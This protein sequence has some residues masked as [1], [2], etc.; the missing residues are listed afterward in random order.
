MGRWRLTGAR[1][2]LLLAGALTVWGQVE[3]WSGLSS[4]V[5]RLVVALA[6]LPAPLSLLFR[7]RW[8]IAVVVVAFGSIPLLEIL[9]IDSDGPF[10]PVLAGLIA[11]GS[12]A[13]YS[14]HPVIAYVVAVLLVWI[15]FVG[16]AGSD[17]TRA[18]SPA[19]LL[20][21]AMLVAMGWAVGRGIA[22]GSL[23]ARLARQ[24]A[25]IAVAEQRLEI[26]RELHDIVA[27]SV[28]VMTMHA[29]GVRRML[30]PG[31]EREALLVV[32][33]TGRET[34]TELQRLLG[35]LRSDDQALEARPRLVDADELLEPARAAGLVAALRIEGDPRPLPEGVDLSAYRILQEAVTN[36]LR[37][38]HATRLD[39]VI[40]YADDAV[41]L[42]ITDDGPGRSTPVAGNGIVGM[43]ERTALWGGSFEAGPV[44]GRGFRVLA[45]VPLP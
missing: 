15:A 6:M 22:V 19:D 1:L 2:D 11:V 32:E 24:Q 29:G 30:A 10:T 27:H 33:R 36:V 3:A 39:A 5:P 16:F 44:P 8:P 42:D 9:G 37:H 26:A 20:W 34:L 21:Q 23:R 12:A 35:V 7:R 45:T 43:R 18:F 28:S 31:A 13:Y 17:G 25:E 41:A 14:R 40:R 38:A 4:S